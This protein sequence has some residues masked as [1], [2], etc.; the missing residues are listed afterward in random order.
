MRSSKPAGFA[1]S[2]AV[3]QLRESAALAVAIFDTA[4]DAII[5]IDE[6]GIVE[7][8]NGAAERMFDY[9]AAEVLGQNVNTLMPAPFAAEHGRYM[10]NY[11]ETGKA[12]IIGIGREVQGMRRDGTVFPIDLAVSEMCVD[13]RRTFAGIIRDITERKRL[14]R[15]VLEIAE[16]EQRRIGQDLHDGLCQ[17][18]TGIAYLVQALQ[19]R[20]SV[21]KS[22]ETPSV[23]DV[24]ALLKESVN[25]A[26]GLSHG[27]YP[28][29]PH[30]DGLMLGLRQLAS[31][32]RE[33]FAVNC[34]FQCEKP[35]R[36]TDNEAATHLYRI[37]QESV[38]NAIRH[39]K[40]SRIVIRLTREG[41][42]LSLAITDNGNGFAPQQARR[43]GLGLRTMAHRASAIGATLTIGPAPKRGVRVQCRMKT[44]Q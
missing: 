28:V 21:E 11:L 19:Q 5:T 18:L 13:G 38:Q 34:V 39:G 8:F 1:S 41:Q 4:V 15:E 14:E 9:K 2:Q 16:R 22:K 36:L 33:F 44:P 10:R 40:A 35:V 17:Q 37:A 30:A 29:D 42:H 25:Q 31:N 24:A 20:L 6:N 43:A 26:R 27:L 23:A 3:G 7:S 32:V 12:K